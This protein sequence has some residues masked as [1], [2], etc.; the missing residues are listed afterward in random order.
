MAREKTS[1]MID[2]PDADGKAEGDKVD[3][4]GITWTVQE[5]SKRDSEGLLHKKV[6]FVPTVSDGKT[7]L[8]LCGNSTDEFNKA[9][10]TYAERY[11]SAGARAAVN[12]A[13]GGVEKKLLRSAKNFAEA[14]GLSTAPENLAKIAALIKQL[15][16]S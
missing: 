15:E 2:A 4:N 3:V 5:F 12:I 6:C 16:V 14:K 13:A 10:R 11:Y 9:L 1:K 8:S 7:F